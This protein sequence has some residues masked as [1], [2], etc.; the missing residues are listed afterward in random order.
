M[1]CKIL[2]KEIELVVIINKEDKNTGFIGISEH[3]GIGYIKSCLVEEGYDV[4]IK[5]IIYSA[6]IDVKNYFSSDSFII[7][8]SAYSDNMN[9][10]IEVARLL[11]E[12][13]PHIHIT[14]GGPQIISY[15]EK[16]LRDNPFIDSVIFLEGEQTFVELAN[17]L[18][19]GQSLEA[20]EGLVRRNEKG[21]VEKYS[22]RPSILNLDAMP[23]PS[24]DT[25]EKVKQKYLY[26]AGSRGCLGGCSFCG[27]T[28]IKS[29]MQPPYVRLRSAK[30]VVEEM[31]YLI[32]KYQVNSFRFTDATFEDPGESG[33]R[34]ANEIFDLIIERNLKISLHLFTR[35]ELVVKE[36][37]DYFLKAKR[38]GVECFYIGVEAGNHADIKLYHKKAS[39]EVSRRAMEK[40]KKA[41]IHVGIGFICFNPYSTYD[42][43]KDN[44]KFLLSTHLGHVFYLLQTR[45]ELFPQAFIKKKM[46]ED[47][48][49]DNFDYRSYFYNYRF[50]D[51]DI[52]RLFHIIKRAYGKEPIYYMDTLLEMDRTWWS[53]Y[54]QGE[55]GKRIGALFEQKDNLCEKYRI[56]NYEFFLKCIDMSANG[57]REE[58]FD[59]L[60]EAYRLDDIYQPFVEIYNK[61]NIRITKERLKMLKG[62]K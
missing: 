46:E 3:L 62:G 55:Q 35:A 12:T 52:E 43:L 21:E 29:C 57:A 38:A 48:L 49:I 42:T 26:I 58:H 15:E 17:R 14:I 39:Y 36:D 4:S 11:K 8:F 28:S 20:C 18:S 37:L 5:N 31:E 59:K 22:Y 40:I 13:Y 45:L 6:D 34:R 56:K 2:K 32:A 33:F 27:E 30:S 9:E 24:R 50:K 51:P 19:Q 7:G 54:L 53:I 41:G 23:Y 16:V 47:G 60:I 1:R 61:I 25:Y 44:A 10:T